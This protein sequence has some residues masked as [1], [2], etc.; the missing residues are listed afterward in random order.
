M[1]EE[2]DTGEWKNRYQKSREDDERGHLRGLG[3]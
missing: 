1:V 3:S 2:S